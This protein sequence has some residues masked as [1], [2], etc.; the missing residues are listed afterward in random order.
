MEQEL[1]DLALKSKDPERKL[2]YC[3]KYIELNPSDSDAWRYNALILSYLG[4]TRTK[5]QVESIEKE[6]ESLPLSELDGGPEFLAGLASSARGDWERAAQLFNE[7]LN[8]NAS[9]AR[10]WLE[11]GEALSL[12]PQRERKEE[13]LICVDKA[14]ELGLGKVL[15]A[16]AMSLK[17]TILT[18][19][20]R[21]E[22]A[23]KYLDECLNRDPAN[24]EALISKAQ[25]A[26]TIGR[27]SG[28]LSDLE[29]ASTCLNDVLTILSSDID[30]EGNARY[31]RL[32]N[33]AIKARESIEAERR[34]RGPEKGLYGTLKSK[35]CVKC[36]SSIP[37]DAHYCTQ[38]G[39]RQ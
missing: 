6:L 31:F 15:E 26:W 22:E 37:A 18:S 33:I 23:V 39:T 25:I 19:L 5:E 21:Y 36:H 24:V 9:F 4:R 16:E 12:S 35:H 30:P 34:K 32:R 38:C 29:E 1:L 13:A 3:S 14:L 11:K 27:R 17:G 8:K 28:K 10:A 2:E 7:V 20:A